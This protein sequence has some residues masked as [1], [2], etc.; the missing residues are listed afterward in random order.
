LTGC[1]TTE[2]KPTASFKVE[3][4]D[5]EGLAPLIADIGLSR[6]NAINDAQKR[7][8]ESVVGVYVSADSLVSKAKLVEDYITS[9]TEGFIQNYKI[10]SEKKDSD[11]YRVR[12]K[13][14][15]RSEDLSKKISEIDINPQKYVTPSISFWIDE[16]SDSQPSQTNI[17][18]LQLMKMFVDAGFV[19]SD[20]KPQEFY[21]NSTVLLND[22]SE[23]LERL[24]S[25]I[26]VI[27]ETSSNFNTDRGLGGLVSYRA[28]LSL[29][30]LM[31]STR[32]IVTTA[33]DAASGIDVNKP[34]SS[35][36]AIQNVARKV[37]QELPQKVLTYL[38]DKAFATLVVRNLQDLLETKRLIR[39]LDSFPTVKDCW[40]KNYS[41]KIA[42]ISMDLKRGTLEEIGKMLELNDN[43]KFKVVNTG[44][45]EMEVEIVSEKK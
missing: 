38:K 36:K 16:K 44:K 17:A 45:Y 18:E 15:V 7:A 30:V 11:F 1:A 37:G 12:I 5:A 24:K 42:V 14:W 22:N 25:D 32:D 27:G 23:N 6:K 8:V 13:A 39:S 34:A 35:E 43:F 33:N 3:I 28:N 29:K 26:V 9:K 4:V 41:D 21:K 31:T 2:T 19:V 20:H 10:L 40:V